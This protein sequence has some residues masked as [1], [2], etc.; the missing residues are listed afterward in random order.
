MPFAVMKPGAYYVSVGRGTTTDTDALIEALESGKIAG[1]GL[2]VVDPE[3]LPADSP[4]WSMEN[5]L[6]SPHIGGIT[7]YNNDRVAVIFA[8]NLEKY[9]SG[10][11]DLMNV[12]DLTESY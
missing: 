7:P 3:P 2:D 1:A 12:V 11:K 5:V 10:S 4:L 9:S 6:I 8:K